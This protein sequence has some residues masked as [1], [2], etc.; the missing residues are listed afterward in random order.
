MAAMKPIDYGEE[1][2]E[3]EVRKNIVLAELGKPLTLPLKILNDNCEFKKTWKKIQEEWHPDEQERIRKKEY[4]REYQKR[5]HVIQKRKEKDEENRKC[6]EYRER[7]R[8][9]YRAYS[10]RPEVRQR[11]LE[12]ERKYRKRPGV[13]ERIRENKRKRYLLKKQGG[14]RDGE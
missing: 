7:K 10:K 11:R 9:Y 4:N 14:V 8:E 12:W 1:V 5:P 6:P 13:S 3:A 2:C